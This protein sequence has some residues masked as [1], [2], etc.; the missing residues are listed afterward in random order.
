MTARTMEE[1]RVEMVR[2]LESFDRSKPERIGS[3][4]VGDN[5][6]QGDL[7]LVCI[8]RLPIGKP[9]NERQLVPGT[10]QGSRHTLRGDATIVTGTTFCNPSGEEIPE[11]LIGPAFV[12]NS[13]VTIEHPEHGDKIL[14]QGTAWQC[15]YQQ[16]YAE[17]VR[18]VA[19]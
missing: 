11:V 18:R 16:A 1:C 17:V 10:T 15:V 14:P 5:V 19:D 12:C 4:S 3:P 13:D 2:S 7:Y 8:D 9:S 6:R